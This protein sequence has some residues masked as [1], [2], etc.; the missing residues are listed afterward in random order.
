METLQECRKVCD[1]YG[2]KNSGKK[3]VAAPVSI[4]N[5]QDL[6]PF[7]LCIGK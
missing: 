7:S 1:Y 3:S 4:M 6:F 2:K 5:I